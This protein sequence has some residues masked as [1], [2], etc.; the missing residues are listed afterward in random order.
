MFP[1]IS[2]L[3]PTK[4]IIDN[5]KLCS[6]VLV[7][8]KHDT[9]RM[10]LQ[11]L[12]PVIIIN[13]AFYVSKK[14]RQLTA[15]FP[16]SKWCSNTGIYINSWK[17]WEDMDTY[18]CEHTALIPKAKLPQWNTS[19]TKS[20]YVVY[21]EVW[22]HISLGKLN[23]NSSPQESQQFYIF[24][25]MPTANKSLLVLQYI[26]KASMP[27]EKIVNVKSIPLNQITSV[28]RYNSAKST[29]NILRKTWDI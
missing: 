18:V 4:H 7:S 25:C 17:I 22:I 23:Q 24:S 11:Y 29:Y 6:S 5:I 28:I 13:C 2:G 1:I 8:V 14:F 20:H 16:L 3:W 15:F 10:Q 26:S 21:Q 27:Q 9:K 12:V 19:W